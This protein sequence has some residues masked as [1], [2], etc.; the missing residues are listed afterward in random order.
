MKPRGVMRASIIA[1]VALVLAP[2]CA[3][4]QGYRPDA[5]V[6]GATRLDPAQL[7][8]TSGE[9]EPGSLLGHGFVGYAG[10]GTLAEAIESNGT[11]RFSAAAGTR[12]HKTL[13]SYAEER[14]PAFAEAWCGQ[15]TARAFGFISNERTV[16]VQS[17]GAQTIFYVPREEDTTLVSTAHFLSRLHVSRD[18]LR[19]I[20]DAQPSETPFPIEVYLRG[21]T[22]ERVTVDMEV[23]HDGDRTTIWR[24]TIRYDEGGTAIVPLWTH[25][26]RIHRQD[27]EDVTAEL[28]EVGGPEGMGPM[29][30]F[31]QGIW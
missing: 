30:A 7:Q 14:G 12:L 23:R 24:A 21:T 22:D 27:T 20:E 3:F 5:F 19:V 9:I 18:R 1:V 2:A 11:V 17:D 26:L 6:I 13:V 31:P 4:A 29:E 16:C 28:V 25:E 8:V 15:F 10:T